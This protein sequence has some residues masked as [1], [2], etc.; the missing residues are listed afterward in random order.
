MTTVKL[1]FVLATFA[2]D[3]IAQLEPLL[4]KF[5]GS[6]VGLSLT[7]KIRVKN[8]LSKKKFDFKIS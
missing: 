7:K 2:L 4:T 6:S 5:E 3:T 1:T 8:V